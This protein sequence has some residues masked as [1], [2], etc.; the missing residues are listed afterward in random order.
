MRFPRLL[1]KVLVARAFNSCSNSYAFIVE[2]SD[3]DNAAAPVVNEPEI[4][5]AEARVSRTSTNKC[6][7]GIG[8]L[9]ARNEPQIAGL[10]VAATSAFLTANAAAVSSVSERNY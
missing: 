10:Q 2:G 1:P 6:Q 3:G 5:G 7:I 4:T 9:G 8:V